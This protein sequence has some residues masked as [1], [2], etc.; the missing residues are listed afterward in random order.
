[1][2]VTT[3]T[4]S[5]LKRLTRTLSY[6]VLPP[7]IFPVWNVEYLRFDEVILAMTILLVVVVVVVIVVVKNHLSRGVTRKK[8]HF[9][10]KRG[11]EKQEA[12][13]YKV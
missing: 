11:R 7:P 1:M 2:Y 4:R 13:D 12:R 6:T 3:I 8:Y 5:H 10:T 9:E